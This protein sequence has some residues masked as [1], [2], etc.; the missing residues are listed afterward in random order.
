[1]AHQIKGTIM[2]TECIPRREL[3][4]ALAPWGPA[5]VKLATLIYNL[6][7]N[8]KQ[9][10]ERLTSLVRRSLKTD[11]EYP[12]DGNIEYVQFDTLSA[13]Y[14]RLRIMLDHGQGLSLYEV[15]RIELLSSML[16]DVIEEMTLDGLRCDLGKWITATGGK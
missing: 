16:Q 15:M 8:E 4:D 1:M 3:L 5:Y 6:P 12:Y 9:L 10:Y 11:D 14:D 7:E 13:L 2:Y